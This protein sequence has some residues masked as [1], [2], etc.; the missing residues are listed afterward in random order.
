[1]TADS[2]ILV[3]LAFAFAWSMGAHYTG[4][5]MGMPYATGSIR[6]W[7]ALATMAVFVVIGA[8]FLSHRVLTTVGHH[9]LDTSRLRTNAASAIIAAAFILT[10]LYN[11]LKIPT[12]TIQILVFSIVGAVLALHVHVEW[13]TIARLAAVWIVAP[14]AALILGF[15]LTAILDRVASLANRAR[16]VGRLLVIA[17]WLASLTMGAN[18]V[19]NATGVFITTHL[20]GFSIAGALG[21]A[22]LALGVLTW[23]RPLL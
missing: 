3:A 13:K 22:G 4:A 5:C 21:G 15:V 11:W 1:M 2:L 23:G 20:S 10:T 16:L 17:R 19:S 8:S 14:F 6:V 18:D 7:P 9:L 12:S